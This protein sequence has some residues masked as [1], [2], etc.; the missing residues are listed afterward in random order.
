MSSPPPSEPHAAAGKGSLGPDA[1]LDLG[2]HLP[3]TLED[4]EVPRRPRQS[5]G[6]NLLERINDLYPPELFGPHPRRL[7]TCEGFEP[8]T[9]AEDPD[10]DAP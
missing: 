10:A 5:R 6:E 4:I 7:T 8:F 9:L 2:H 3:T 1:L